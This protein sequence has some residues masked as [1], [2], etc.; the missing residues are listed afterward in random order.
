MTI[1]YFKSNKEMLKKERRI[2]LKRAIYGSSKDR[3][4]YCIIRV[5]EKKFVDL[6]IYG[7]VII[8][9]EK[10]LKLINHWHERLERINRRV[11]WG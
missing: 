7:N 5:S 3:L 4:D 2:A 6:V 9:S 1:D 10:N 8:E 11:N